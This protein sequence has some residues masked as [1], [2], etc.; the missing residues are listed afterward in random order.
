MLIDDV[1]ITI[2]SGNGGKGAVAFNK[3]LNQYG[4]VGGSGGDGG[5]VYFE[6]SSDFSSLGKY[7]FKKDFGAK[8]GQ[9]GRGQFRDGAK[10]DDLISPVP[11]GTVIHNLTTGTTQEIVFVGERVLVAKGGRGGKGNFHFRSPSNT[12]PKQC[13]PGEAGESFSIRLE[14]KLIADVGFIGLPNVGKTSLLTE[15]TRAQSKVANYPFTTLE[16]N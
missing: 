1:T 6:G 13:E 15:L 5:S 8:N 3:N 9:Y 7:R 11:V 10:A 14:L 2:Q 12:R 4:P 16:P